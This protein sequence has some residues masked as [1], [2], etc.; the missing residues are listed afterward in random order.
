MTTEVYRKPGLGAKLADM[1]AGARDQ[2]RESFAAADRLGI[3]AARLGP[4]RAELAFHQGDFA[5]V[6]THLAAL[7]GRAAGGPWGKV[8][9]FWL[10]RGARR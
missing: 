5:A 6:R 4:R 7:D 10:D 8:L 3:P 2:A 9:R 1:M